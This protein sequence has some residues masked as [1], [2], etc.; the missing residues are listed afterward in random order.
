M[1]IGVVQAD[2]SHNLNRNA[3]SIKFSF[4]NLIPEVALSAGDEGPGTD[5]ATN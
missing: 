3:S 2:L 1:Y 5:A 4:I